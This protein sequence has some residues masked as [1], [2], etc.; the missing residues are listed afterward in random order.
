M[1]MPHCRK[2]VLSDY[3]TTDDILSIPVYLSLMPRDRCKNILAYL[4]FADDEIPKRTERLWK[5]R[6]IMNMIRNRYAAFLKH[7]QKVVIGESL[8]VFRGRLAFRQY[9]PSKRHRF[10]IIYF[11]ILIAKVGTSWT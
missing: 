2:H 5:V 11:V 8:V 6:K 7:F 9:I 1:L 10:G 3:W 4:C